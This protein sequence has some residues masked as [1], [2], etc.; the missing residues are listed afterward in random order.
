MVDYV[1]R[2]ANLYDQ[3]MAYEDAPNSLHY[4]TRFLDGLKPGVRV[5]VALQKPRDLDAAY[6]LALLHE[7]LGEGVTPMN[8]YMGSRSGAFPLPLPPKGRQFDDKRVSDTLKPVPTEDK[9]SALRTFRKAK[10][11]CFVCGE[12]WSK[13]HVCKSSVQLHVVQELIDHIQTGAR[14]DSDHSETDIVSI[15]TCDLR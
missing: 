1:D 13:D 2:F 15:A 14:S 11:L 10:G 6:D 7:E 8:S 12:H 4:T 3:L 5:A 9:W